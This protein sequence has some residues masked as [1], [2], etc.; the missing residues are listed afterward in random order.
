MDLPCVDRPTLLSPDLK[1]TGHTL[2][3][4]AHEPTMTLVMRGYQH[5]S[6]TGRGT[7][8][9]LRNVGYFLVAWFDRYLKGDR[10]AKHRLLARRVNGVRTRQLLS[11]TFRSAV[12]LPGI[13]CEDYALCLGR[14]R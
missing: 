13:D 14:R 4:S 2:W 3:K 11:T 5:S 6:F 8:A 7:E 1:L 12:F 10:S 9:Q